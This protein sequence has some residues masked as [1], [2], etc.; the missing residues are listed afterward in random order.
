[1]TVLR[2]DVQQRG[3]TEEAFLRREAEYAAELDRERQRVAGVRARIT[4]LFG[5]P[6]QERQER[7]V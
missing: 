1:M 5:P 2:R 6:K 3:E 4:E 7:V